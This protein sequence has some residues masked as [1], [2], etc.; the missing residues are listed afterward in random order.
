MRPQTC[1]ACQEAITNPICP[2]CLE[3]E[4]EAWLVEKKPYIVPYLYG[5]SDNFMRSW[6]TMCIICGNRMGVCGHC[7]TK[8]ILDVLRRKAPE[9]EEQFLLMFNFQ[10]DKS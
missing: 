7:Y 1:I 10:I 4:I 6:V 8:D 3:R 2:E 9:L 5:L